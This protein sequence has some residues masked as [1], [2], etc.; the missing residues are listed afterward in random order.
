MDTDSFLLQS[1]LVLTLLVLVF[2]IVIDTR[3]LL[4]RAY[5]HRYP[6][7]PMRDGTGPASA[8]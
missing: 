7:V 8:V 2:Y 3:E 1:Y 4:Q 5:A 6:P